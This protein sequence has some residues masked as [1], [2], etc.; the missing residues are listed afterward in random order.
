MRE[1]DREQD[2]R[3]QP[4]QHPRSGEAAEHPC[5]PL[6]PGHVRELQ[7]HAG[8]G[9]YEETDHHADV[10]HALV[11]V[12]TAV[13]LLPLLFYLRGLAVLLP[14]GSREPQSHQPGPCVQQREGERPHQQR[15]HAPERPEQPRILVGVVV[16][17]VGQVSRESAM[18]FFMTLA[19]GRDD[20]LAAQRRVDV[21]RRENLVRSVTVVALGGS[22]RPQTRGLAVD[23]VEEGL[24]LRRV[25]TAALLHHRHAEVRLID[26]PDGVRGVTVLAG[27]QFPVGIRVPGP[28]DTG[29]EPLLDAVMACSAGTGDVIVVHRGGRIGGGK[30][31][32][33]AVA[34]DT[35]G[36][37]DQ[38]TLH[39]PLAVNTVLVAVDEVREIALMAHGSRLACAVAAPT[40]FGHVAGERRR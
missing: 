22:R 3:A 5:G 27:G 19:A 7:R 32:M 37:H 1:E 20:V 9:Q 24:G 11:T 18:R 2:D 39:E 23:R 28:V 12:E 30:L 14:I 21:R 38:A 15:R 16:R 26:S 8:Q 25:T 35:G 34:T 13:D 36:G 6:R 33:R 31:A 40:E 4:V 10:Q 17:G 29:P